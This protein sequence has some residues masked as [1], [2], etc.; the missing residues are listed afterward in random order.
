MHYDKA[1]A[2]KDL[3]GLLAITQMIPDRDIVP[4]IAGLVCQLAMRD[5]CTSKDAQQF[6]AYISAF[7]DEMHDRNMRNAQGGVS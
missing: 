3:Q 1:Q 2:D 7:Q 4:M 6:L 5:M